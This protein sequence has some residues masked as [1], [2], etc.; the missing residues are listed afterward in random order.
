MLFSFHYNILLKSLFSC[1]CNT[2]SLFFQPSTPPAQAQY[3][4]VPLI[5]LVYRGSSVTCLY[6]PGT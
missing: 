4:V 2:N 3:P 6:S 1:S 5:S